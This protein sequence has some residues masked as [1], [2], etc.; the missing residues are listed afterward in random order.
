GA[1]PRGAA[2][3]V[4]R[5]PGESPGDGPGPRAARGARPGGTAEA[6]AAPQ[7]ANRPPRL[8]RYGGL[9]TRI[10]ADDEGR[11]FPRTVTEER[12]RGILARAADWFKVTKDPETGEKRETPALPPLHVVKDVLATPNLPLPVL[13]GITEG[14]VFA[15]DGPLH[16]E[17][18]YPPA[19]RLL[20]RPAAGLTIPAV[21]PRPTQEERQKAG[22][23]IL[24]ELLGDFPFTSDAERAHAVA[25]F[26]L[27]FVRP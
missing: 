23:F 19:T 16:A 5:A 7:A 17:P 14:P 27:P 3:P 9:L 1:V 4:G 25:L 18:G 20:Y 2:G 13:V 24:T 8:F 26:L 15:G 6:G 21:S 10:E 22:R 12:L 11:P